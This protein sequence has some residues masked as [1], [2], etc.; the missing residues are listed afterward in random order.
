MFRD[1]TEQIKPDLS[2]NQKITL[3]NTGLKV[4]V[5]NLNFYSNQ[6]VIL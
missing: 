4:E 5:S 2:I 6:F 3:T 1:A